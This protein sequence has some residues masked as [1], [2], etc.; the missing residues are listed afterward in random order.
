M[1]KRREQ[2]FHIRESGRSA[3][4]Y[5]RYRTYWIDARNS[6]GKRA[7]LETHD[8]DIALDA[9]KE[10]LKDLGNGPNTLEAAFEKYAETYRNSKRPS[11]IRRTLPFLR[12][13]IDAIG[14]H[15]D[16]SSITNEDIQ[17]Y[18]SERGKRGVSRITLQTDAG[19]IRGF[20]NKLLAKRDITFDP[21]QSLEY[22]DGQDYDPRS[23][24]KKAYSHEEIQRYKELTR[25]NQYAHDWI[26][27]G[28]ATGM[29]PAEQ[30]HLR[31]TDFDEKLGALT[32]QGWGGWRPKTEK[33]WRTLRLAEGVAALAVLQRR[34]L[35]MHRDEK[36]WPLFATSVGTVME[37]NN[38]RRTLLSCLPKGMKIRPYGLRHTFAVR[39]LADGTPM[40]VISTFMGHESLKTTEGYAKSDPADQPPLPDTG[41]PEKKRP[42][43]P[44]KG[45]SHKRETGNA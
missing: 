25:N 7:S 2:K 3:V 40:Q 43:P 42:K 45:D 8:P 33:A 26:V 13:F 27:V 34:K 31:G 37:I 15:R 32:I 5:L 41:A 30:A 36:E 4:V 28:V 12:S 22:P 44:A 38:L 21:C 14:P 29:R 11:S 1:A 24:A 6:G 17:A 20:F 18:I 23:R 9:A 35:A 19:R 10:Y 16:P 39:A